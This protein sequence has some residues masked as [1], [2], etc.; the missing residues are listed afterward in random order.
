MT[1]VPTNPLFALYEPFQ[2]AFKQPSRSYSLQR[3]SQFARGGITR[4]NRCTQ[5][6]QPNHPPCKSVNS[7]DYSLAVACYFGG[8]SAKF[9]LKLHFPHF[10]LQL[11]TRNF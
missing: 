1:F 11:M 7:A 2:F 5:R 6:K 10:D 4:A 9:A 8:K 3:H